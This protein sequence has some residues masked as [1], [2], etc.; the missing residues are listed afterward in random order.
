[1]AGRLVAPGDLIGT[2]AGTTGVFLHMAFHPLEAQAWLFTQWSE[3]ANLMCQHFLQ[4]L[5]DFQ[6]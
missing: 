6:C 3:M 5:L 2:T 1:M 4:S